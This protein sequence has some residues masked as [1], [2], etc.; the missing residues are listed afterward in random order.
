MML[1]YTIQYNMLRMLYYN[2]ALRTLIAGAGAEAAGEAFEA[3]R[4]DG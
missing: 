4:K 2:T 3:G 1:S